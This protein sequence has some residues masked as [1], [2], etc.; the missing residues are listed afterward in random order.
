MIAFI[1]ICSPS[2]IGNIK[3]RAPIT[4]RHRARSV[5]WRSSILG[6]SWLVLIYSFS[7]QCFL[8]HLKK[9]R[10]NHTRGSGSRGHAKLPCKLTRTRATSTRSGENPNGADL[11]ISRPSQRH[12]RARSKDTSCVRGGAE[13]S[14]RLQVS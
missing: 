14:S 7:R 13:A 9:T 2:R 11:G 8:K 6:W 5:L 3:D 4:D 1:G 12:M 10:G